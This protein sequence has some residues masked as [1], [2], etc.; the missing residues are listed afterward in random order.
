METFVI[1]GGQQ[2]SGTITP[3][4]NKNAA[5]PL[6]AAALLTDEPLTLH[7]VPFIGDVRVKLEMLAGLGMAHE[8]IAPN[9]FGYTPPTFTRPSLIRRW[10]GEF[11]PRFCWRGR[12]WLAP[13]APC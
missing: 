6:L 9:S 3:A 4:G 12:C 1:Q 2:L 11:A 7:N 5:L 8:W 10:R 13:D